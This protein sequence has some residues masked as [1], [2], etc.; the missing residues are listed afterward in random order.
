MVSFSQVD[1]NMKASGKR[2]GWGGRKALNQYA[3]AI[4]DR[5][6][7][8]CGECAGSCPNGVDVPSVLRS[9]TYLEG[10]G[11]EDLAREAYRELGRDRGALSCLSCG[12]CAVSCR[13]GLD[14]KRV[15]RRAHRHLA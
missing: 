10:Y 11:Q 8:M 7:G 14:V 13:L 12:S 1:E 2:L 6:C 15:A 9:L 4:G 5:H 3:R